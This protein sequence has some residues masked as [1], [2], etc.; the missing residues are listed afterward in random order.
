[1]RR[2]LRACVMT[3]IVAGAPLAASA[4]TAIA[5][6]VRPG[7]MSAGAFVGGELDNADNWL[8]FGADVRVQ[9]ARGLELNPRFTFRPLDNGSIREIDANVLK[10]LELA[11][12][13]RIRPFAGIGGAV[14]TVSPEGFPSETKVGL[15]LVSGARIAMSSGAG[16]EPFF[17]AQYT[18]V[19]NQLNTFAFVVGA[20]FKLRH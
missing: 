19:Q 8:T 15:N 7:V 17:Q 16:Y 20:S 5:D 13:G 18:I 2:I 12:P 4:Q 11:Q 6:E 1:M 3:L 14:R 10:N 9:M